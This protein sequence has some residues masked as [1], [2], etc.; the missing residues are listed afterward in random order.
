VTTSDAR[1]GAQ[2][3][4]PRFPWLLLIVACWATFII[5]GSGIARSPFLQE[6]ARD[7]TSSF[8]AIANLFSL[9]AFAWGIAS[10]FAGAASDRFGRRPL[11]IL[12]HL[13]L[14]IGTVGIAY[15]HSY[16]V[17][18]LWTLV[19]GVG[20]GAHM[21]VIF[22]AVS[23]R[24]PTVQRGRAL[25]GIMA[26]QSLSFVVGVPLATW[27][28]SVVGWRG[29]MIGI[30]AADVLAIIGLWAMLPGG[31]GGPAGGSIPWHRMIP[32]RR[33]A[34]LLAAGTTE[35]VSYGVSAVYFAT[36]LKLRYDLGLADL[37][38]PLAVMAAGNL[39]GNWVGGRIA[40]GVPDRTRSFALSSLATGV[41][42]ILLFA[43]DLGLWPAVWLGFAYALVNA[44]GRPAIIA[45][46]SEVP[47]ESR[48]A[49]LGLNITCASVG[50]ITAAAIGGVLIER[51]GLW[52]LAPLT[53]SL[54][55]LG[56]VLALGRR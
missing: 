32:D 21:G 34:A 19:A 48:G 12:A 47:N 52:S 13:A 26:G 20:G 54:S 6:M 3:P 53:A 5:T 18:A 25:G 30:A 27:V 43:F 29:V 9:T 11:L 31:R 39:V 15:S 42:G 7:L 17:I 28:G 36:L 50:W 35:R 46:L 55:L 45:V 8:L 22:A 49:I 56:A 37:T 23:D 33:L 10:L 1:A 24:V 41:A 14:I 44:L 40:D 2:A 51:Y 4:V 16:P 38:L